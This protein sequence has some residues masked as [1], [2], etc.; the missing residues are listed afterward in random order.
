M[1]MMM[2]E[3]KGQIPGFHSRQHS[4]YWRLMKTAEEMS[5]VVDVVIAVV[6]AVVL[7]A[8]A[9]VTGMRSESSTA[10]FLL[11]L[12]SSLA[13]LASFVPHCRKWPDE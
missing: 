12:S 7:R 5:V 6:T 4:P 11:L 3:P 10:W 13:K 1:M 2:A 9:G 8:V